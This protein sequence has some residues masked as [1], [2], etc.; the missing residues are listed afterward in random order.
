MGKFVRESLPEPMEYFIGQELRLTGPGTWKTTR[1]EFHGGSDSMR[2]NT[3]TGAWVCMSCGEKGG[4]VLAY[5]MKQ[6]RQDFIAAARELGAWD[7]EG[8]SRGPYKPRP[9]SANAALQV[10]AFEATLTGVAAGNLS[11]G[12]ELSED[13]LARLLTAASRI[14]TIAEAYR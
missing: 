9:L 13:D 11:N 10:L 4:D 12:V 1:C 2:I 6:H 14:N 8:D 7:D 5:Q 3:G